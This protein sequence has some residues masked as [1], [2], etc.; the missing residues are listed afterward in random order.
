MA[1]RQL[2]QRS[3][4]DIVLPDEHKADMWKAGADVT[5]GALNIKMKIDSAKMNNFLADANLQAMKVTQEWRVANESNPFDEGAVRGLNEQYAKIFRQYEGKIGFLSQGQWQQSVSKQTKQW[6]ADNLQWGMQ[7]EIKNVELSINSSIKKDMAFYQ[8]IGQTGDINKAVTTA[9]ERLA[10]LQDTVSGVIGEESFKRLTQDYEADAIKSFIVGQADT[11]PD[12]ALEL[13]K[14]EKTVEKIGDPENVKLL[15]NYAIKQKNQKEKEVRATEIAQYKDVRNKILS[16]EP[17]SFNDIDEMVSNKNDAFKLKQ[18]LVQVDNTKSDPLK[19]SMYLSSLANL[20]LDTQKEA[21]AL[22][23]KVMKDPN[24]SR[25]DKNT[26]I[27]TDIMGGMSLQDMKAGKTDFSQKKGLLNLWG[28]IKKQTNDTDAVE[29][30]QKFQE[31]IADDDDYFTMMKKSQKAVSEVVA[32]NNPNLS[33]IGTEWVEIKDIYGGVAMARRNEN[34]VL[35]IM[36]V[37]YG[38][39][40]EEIE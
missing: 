6:Q 38:E 29:A 22:Y 32:K 21:D 14:D 12:K 26:I 31:W 17:M 36:D 34:G 16:D 39:K 40:E 30:F 23:D 8:S 7:R 20:P 33:K 15:E 24:L 10:G 9:R 3:V 1:Q 19:V 35:E 18:F 27:K 25:R 37:E 5:Q 4:T 11:D 28:I 2:A 13:L